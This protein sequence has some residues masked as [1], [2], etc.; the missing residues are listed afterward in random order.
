L[1]RFGQNSLNGLRQRHSDVIKMLK[2]G[3]LILKK[4]DFLLNLGKKENL[5]I[6]KKEL[7]I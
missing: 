5:K 3:T 2:I 7:F 4:E 1:V 6:S